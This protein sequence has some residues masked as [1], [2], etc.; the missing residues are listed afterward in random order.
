[1]RRIAALVV[2]A[3]LTACAGGGADS[4]LA[5]APALPPPPLAQPA[6]GAIF[7]AGTGYAGLA[8]GTR[9]RAVGDLV[10][11]VLVE[12]TA[13]SSAAQSKTER[14]GS[15]TLTAPGLGEVGRILSDGLNLGAGGSFRGTGQA[16]QSNALN[17]DIAVTIAELRPG[18]VALLRG[19]K[20]L[21][22]AGGQDRIRLTGLARLA[23]ITADNRIAS[24][25]L[26]DARIEVTGR[27]AVASSGRPGWLSRFFS[28][29]SPF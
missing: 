12:R 7:N 17:G 29:V 16:S 14:N 21:D 20:R 9:A 23:D 11:V 26:A 4:P 5:Y 3:T 18:G 19:E 28:A 8:E 13:V 15:T 2:T 1:M 27:G 10:T 6:N 25:Q 22:T 24:I